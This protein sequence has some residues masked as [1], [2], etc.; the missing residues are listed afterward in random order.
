MPREQIIIVG[1][2]PAGCAAAVQCCRL[3]VSPCLLDRTGQA[4]GLT[5]NAFMIENYPCLD[6]TDGPSFAQLLARHIDRF[7]I[8]VK[9]T[10]VQSIYRT[11]GGYAVTC[12][13]DEMWATSVILAVGTTPI[14]LTIPGAPSLL[15]NG[16]YHSIVEVADRSIDSALVIGGGEAALDYALTL[17]RQGARVD[18]VVRSDRLRAQGRLVSL[19]RNNAD[20][21]LNFS[22]TPLAIR[23]GDRG[24]ILDVATSSSTVS[25]AGDCALAAIG[26]VNALPGLL[27][28]LD[29]GGPVAV[30]TPSPGLFVA[31]DARVGNLGQ[32]GMAIGDGLAA[33]MAA[34]A[35]LENRGREER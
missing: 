21:K 2:G 27:K 20:I 32:A 18:V 12:D 7:G 1:A 11:N 10:V 19:V 24:V 23:A 25:M 3:G 30:S 35:F 29:V 33:A 31:G 9:K 8:Q 15:G 6:P 14:S 4:G 28:G 5:R 26:R 13:T 17:A 16:L 34:V 22:M